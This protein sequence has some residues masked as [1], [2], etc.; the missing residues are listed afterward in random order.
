MLM[1]QKMKRLRTVLEVLLRKESI[2]SLKS[3]RKQLP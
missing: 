3:Q 1:R 2:R